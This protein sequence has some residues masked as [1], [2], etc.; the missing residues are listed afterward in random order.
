MG[1]RSKPQALIIASR[2]Q[3][4]EA[5]AQLCEIRR[6]TAAAAAAMNEAIDN[7]KAAAA[8]RAE[9]LNRRRRELESALAAYAQLNKPELFPMKKSLEEPHGIFGFR[10]S[11]K[12]RTMPKSTMAMVLD[13][14]KSWGVGE[15]VRIKESV[16]KE[17]MREWPD[18]R[19]AAVGMRR[20]IKDEFFIELKEE[21]LDK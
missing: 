4:A 3:A 18:D 2:E 7:A 8:A 20:V 11:T 10:K 14:I 21:E 12:I 6:E 5:L 13:R 9:P 16:D 19:L 1:K 15:A 17:A